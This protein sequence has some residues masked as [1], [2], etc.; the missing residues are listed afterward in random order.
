MN[1]W[2]QMAHHSFELFPIHLNRHI[3]MTAS[4][5]YDVTLF[6]QMPYKQEFMAKTRGGCV[7][8]RSSAGCVWLEH[9]EAH[10]VERIL[11]VIRSYF[12]D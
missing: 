8:A 9:Q 6:L 10:Q 5:D 11:V 4:N 7:F 2:V 1:V 3:E 12:K